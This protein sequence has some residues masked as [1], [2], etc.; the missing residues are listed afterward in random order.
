MLIQHIPSRMTVSKPKGQKEYILVHDQDVYFADKTFK[1][2]IREVIT[3]HALIGSDPVT[4]QII[5]D[6]AILDWHL[7]P[8]IWHILRDEY[9]C[10]VVEEVS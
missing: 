10:L 7:R 9:Q 8:E 2:K 4:I 3:G 5:D 6:D 1:T